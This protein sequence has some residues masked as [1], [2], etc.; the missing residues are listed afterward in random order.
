MGNTEQ[1][2]VAGELEAPPSISSWFLSPAGYLAIKGPGKL[3]PL[4]LA[5][6][7]GSA[8]VLPVT[9]PC[10]LFLI[11]PTLLMI[12]LC[13]LYVAT[14]SQGRNIWT[15]CA[16]VSIIF[17]LWA[18]Q[19]WGFPH[20]PVCFCIPNHCPIS[21]LSDD[22]QLLLLLWNIFAVFSNFFGTTFSFFCQHVSHQI[23]QIFTKFSSLRVKLRIIIALFL[24][25]DV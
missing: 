6:Q 15:I 24:E 22:D 12:K 9:W 17:C 23:R 18:E 14:L 19:Y 3:Y 4:S 7:P 1:C 21:F 16:K 8:P 2:I 13:F 25:Q 20:S 11:N 10:S 5:L